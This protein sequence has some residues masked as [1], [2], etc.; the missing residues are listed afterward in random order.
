MSGDVDWHWLT[1]RGQNVSVY[2]GQYGVG[3][4]S[5]DLAVGQTGTETMVVLEGTFR[6]QVGDASHLLDAGSSISYERSIGRS[7]S[8]SGDEPAVGLWIIVPGN[9]PAP[10]RSAGAGFQP[11]NRGSG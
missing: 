9:P 11:L 8:N 10:R 1:T 2:Q 6:V 7:F 4:S 5:Y 3:S